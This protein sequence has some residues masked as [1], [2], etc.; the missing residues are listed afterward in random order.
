MSSRRRQLLESQPR[1]FYSVAEMAY[2]EHHLA[3]PPRGGRRA[4]QAAAKR[5]ALRVVGGG[6][7][8]PTR[9]CP[10]ARCSSAI[11]S[12]ASVQRGHARPRPDRGVAPRLVRPRRHGARR[13]R[14]GRFH[15]RR[16][17]A[18]R[19]GA[20]HLPAALPGR[21]RAPA[22][23]PRPGSSRDL[24]SSDFTWHGSGGGTVLRALHRGRG[25]LLRGREHRLR[26]GTSRC[27]WSRRPV[28]GRR[29]EP[30]PTALDGYAAESAPL[31]ADALH[32]RARRVDFES[33]RRSSSRT[34]TGTTTSLP[35]HRR[36]GGR[37]AASRSTPPGVPL[38]RRAAG[39]RGQ[40]R[41]GVHGLLRDAARYSKR[42]V[43]DAA[44]P[45][46]VPRRSRRC[47]GTRG[48][49]S[50]PAPSRSSRS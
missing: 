11:S 33:P 10:R 36:V 42:A 18:H 47:S 27:R 49:G 6:V 48:R 35:G 29:P 50:S 40:S 2:L 41:A 22:R 7:T 19:R 23:A 37:G 3:G 30:S 14:R 24:G 1:A 28:H 39:R 31:R 43:R 20:D 44:R 26:V 32:V 15:E 25:A 5:G 46:F 21:R 12:T 17:L 34:S 9:C 8:S 4:P 45:F 38:A 13:P 16:L